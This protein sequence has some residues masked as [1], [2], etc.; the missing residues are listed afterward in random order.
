M[1]ND[2]ARCETLVRIKCKAWEAMGGRKGERDRQ[3]QRQ[4]Q[5]YRHRQTETKKQRQRQREK[6]RDRGRQRQRDRD[7]DRNTERETET[8]R[9]RQTDRDRRQGDT[10][11]NKQTGRRTK[12]I[13]YKVTAVKRVT[14]L[15]YISAY[16][17]NYTPNINAHVW[18]NRT[19]SRPKKKT[20]QVSDN[21]N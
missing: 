20:Q 12:Y 9:D 13:R 18:L 3:R 7:R 5:T 4:R 6:Q 10:D 1:S 17:A 14:S 11:T 8:D 2:F 21:G 19:S 16:S 15:T